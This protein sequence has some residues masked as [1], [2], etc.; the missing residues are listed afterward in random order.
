M[1]HH[2]S[3]NAA[4]FQVQVN[5]AGKEQAGHILVAGVPAAIPNAI[6]FLAQ[7]LQFLPQHSGR[8]VVVKP[9]RITDNHIHLAPG[10]SHRPHHIAGVVSPN[11]VAPLLMQLLHLG[12]G[13]L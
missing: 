8:A 7:A 10:Q 6:A 12:N 1:R 4:V 5:A 11:M 2:K 9:G 3:D 13:S